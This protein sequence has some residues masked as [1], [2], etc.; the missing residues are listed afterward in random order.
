MR[1]TA[2][3]VAPLVAALLFVSALP[4]STAAH[5]VHHA[6]AADVRS[7]HPRDYCQW[8]NYFLAAVYRKKEGTLMEG[9]V[10]LNCFADSVFQAYID[11][12]HIQMKDKDG[13][14]LLE[15]WAAHPDGHEEDPVAHGPGKSW[16]DASATTK[17]TYHDA[18]SIRWWRTVSWFAFNWN[19]GGG[20]AWKFYSAA[21]KHFCTSTVH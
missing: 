8:G 9:R 17:C 21:S 14:W 10:H 15:G 5:R 7:G 13:E 20:M 1:R 18:N 6:H 11:D 19:F 3:V 12:L 2:F 4:A 16:I